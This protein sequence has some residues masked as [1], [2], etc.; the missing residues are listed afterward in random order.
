MASAEVLPPPATNTAVARPSSFESP[1]FKAGAVEHQAPLDIVSH[2]DASGPTERGGVPTN[3]YDTVDPAVYLGPRGVQRTMVNKQG[4]KLQSYFYPAEGTAKCVLQFVH[5]HGA[6]FLFELL[7]G[8]APGK[9][10]QYEGS[11]VQRLNAAGVSVCGID[12]QGCGR[13]EGLKSLRF[14]VE[15][16]DDYVNDVLQLSAAIPAAGG[17][18]NEDD[19]ATLV[20]EGFAGLPLFLS[21]ISLG[22]CIAFTA[23]SRRPDLFCGVLLL[24]PML[25]LERVSRQ[26]LNPYLRP[27]ATMLSRMVPTAAIVATDRNTLYP[28]IQEMWDKDELTAHGKTRV[29]NANEY[30]RATEAAGRLMDS[31]EFPFIVFHSENDTMC[32][33]DGS[34][35]LYLKAKSQD[36]TLRLVNQMWHVLVKESGN[37]AICSE[38]ME[39]M[40]ARA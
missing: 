20:P 34:K 14:Y 9:P 31:A 39:W 36:K 2:P 5:G 28:D 33:P 22:G 27:I 8:T 30:L 11:W 16:F 6:Y 32:D 38:M 3:F 35:Q 4:L 40:L 1:A 37:E 25:S 10:Q 21:G 26:G 29:R 18:T 19:D 7:K 24:A 13:S 17:N 12:N 23:A 15:S